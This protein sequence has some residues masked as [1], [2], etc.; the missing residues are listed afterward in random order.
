MSEPISHPNT[1]HLL[2]WLTGVCSL[3]VPVPTLPADNADQTGVGIQKLFNR[4]LLA[5]E[6]AAQGGHGQQALHAI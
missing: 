2:A 5:A 3:A 6:R 1:K 4:L